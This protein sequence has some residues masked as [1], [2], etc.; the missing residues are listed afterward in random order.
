M[1]IYIFLTAGAA[2]AV[3]MQGSWLVENRE[4]ATVIRNL[5]IAVGVFLSLAWLAVKITES[6][7][8]GIVVAVL[9]FAGFGVIIADEAKARP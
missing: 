1:W 5:A 7:A 2:G 6:M 9:A 3:A 4:H 8:V